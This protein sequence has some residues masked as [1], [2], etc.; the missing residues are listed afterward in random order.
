MNGNAVLYNG[1]G[2]LGVFISFKISPTGVT[3]ITSKKCAKLMRFDG[4]SITSTDTHPL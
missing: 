1:M 2:V 4:H 3:A